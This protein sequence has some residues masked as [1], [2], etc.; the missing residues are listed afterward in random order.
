MVCSN[1][2]PRTF[3]NPPVQG[4]SI[5]TAYGA[6]H[7]VSALCENFANELCTSQ[8]KTEPGTILTVAQNK[9]YNSQPQSL[10]LCNLLL[11]AQPRDYS[12]EKTGMKKMKKISQAFSF[13][14]KR[15][16]RTLEL[17]YSYSDIILL[18]PGGVLFLQRERQSTL[19]LV[20]L[21]QCYATPNVK[22]FI[23]SC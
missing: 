1:L 11:L 5:R 7:L 2:Q 9:E 6:C 23:A 14:F 18:Y 20:S 4:N 8:A 16:E 3:P 21:F 10:T 17:E 13:S 15:S 19:S 12:K 22:R